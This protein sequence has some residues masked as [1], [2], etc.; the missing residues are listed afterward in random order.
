LHLFEL[1][2]LSYFP[3]AFHEYMTD[4]LYFVQTRSRMQLQAFVDPIR[5]LLDRCS[6]PSIVDLCAGGAGPWPV[7]AQMIGG[8]QPVKVR[9]TDLSP[10]LPAFERARAQSGGVIDF[11]AEP[12]D[13]TH[14]PASLT[15]ARTIFN[16]FHHLR[17]EQA[18][19][20]LRDAA[21]TRRP[22]GVF[23]LLDRKALH[24]LGMCMVPL[25]V[26]LSTPFIRPFRLGRLFWTYAVPVVP[27]ASIFDGM[28]S[29]LRIYS[30]PELE[31]LVSDIACHDYEWEIGNLKI[32]PVP[33]P[34]L[35]GYPT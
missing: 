22:I 24:A 7:L 6:D 29:M 25:T 21:D 35:L 5:R 9:L 11:V 16:G 4:Y 20:V 15:G 18:R 2:D 26:M 19:A 28:V 34:Y 13:A 30:V 32:G 12:V 8:D 31:A 23:E 14:V 10:N 17:P 33:V 1:G 3:R 27:L